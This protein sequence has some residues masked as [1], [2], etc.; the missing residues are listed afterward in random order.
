VIQQT[1]LIG[2]AGRSGGV[3]TPWR[4]ARRYG[5]R[6]GSGAGGVAF[7]IK[8]CS[9]PSRAARWGTGGDFWDGGGPGWSIPRRTTLASFHFIELERGETVASQQVQRASNTSGGSQSSATHG[10]HLVQAALRLTLG[11][12]VRKAGS[13]VAPDRLRSRLTYHRAMFRQEMEATEDMVNE[14]DPPSV[15]TEI[16]QRRYQ[17]R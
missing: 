15:T 12:R 17:E 11:K 13:L 3:W 10:H 5:C 7:S 14:V 9:M 4:K 2:D 1:E 8:R 16:V 6:P